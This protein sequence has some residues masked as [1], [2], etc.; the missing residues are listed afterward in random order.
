MPG[1]HERHVGAGPRR[2]DA[3]APHAGGLPKPVGDGGSSP[4]AP[5]R[6]GAGGGLG[7]PGARGGR[8]AG[9]PPAGGGRG[10]TLPRPRRQRGAQRGGTDLDGR[11]A[12]WTCRCGQDGRRAAVS[13]G[14]SDPGFGHFRLGLRG[15]SG[16][17]E[18]P[19]RRRLRGRASE[20]PGVVC[21]ASGLGGVGQGV[22]PWGQQRLGPPS[23]VPRR[24]LDRRPRRGLGEHSLAL[25]HR[26][27][28]G[29]CVL[30]G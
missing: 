23:G 29:H 11:R 13:A 8:A 20:L 2:R 22:Q 6:T 3:G 5:A 1:G 10:R 9:R 25:P 18:R 4:C 19:G 15:W 21:A 14:C 24:R 26:R 7:P 17:P 16:G 27:R 28:S 12:A 30:G